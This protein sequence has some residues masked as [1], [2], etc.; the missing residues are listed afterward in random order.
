MTGKQA[1]SVTDAVLRGTRL[2]PPG[3]LGVDVGMTL[4]KVARGTETGV[5]LEARETRVVFDGDGRG[6]LH[7]EEGAAAGLTGARAG[8]LR[9]GAGAMH[10]QET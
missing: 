5:V 8:L 1:H 2:L 3:A 9:D 7:R 4:T 10:V 6:I